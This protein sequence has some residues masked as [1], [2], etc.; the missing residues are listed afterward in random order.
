MLPQL[1]A[2]LGQ[3]QGFDRTNPSAKPQSYS[4]NTPNL[5]FNA[6]QPAM[7]AAP[8]VQQPQQ[9][10]QP[11]QQPVNPWLYQPGGTGSDWLRG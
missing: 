4:F 5:G 2:Q 1:I 10:Q 7:F 3:N 6:P 9:P 8:Q 11:A